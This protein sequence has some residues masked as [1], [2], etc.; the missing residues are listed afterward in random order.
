MGLAFR[1]L[2][3]VAA[4]VLCIGATS[5]DPAKAAQP[6]AQPSPWPEVMTLGEAASFLR[7]TPV[8]LGQ[9]ADWRQVPGRRIGDQWRFSRAALLEWLEGAWGPYIAPYEPVASAAGA[10]QTAAVPARQPYAAAATTQPLGAQALP[11]AAMA[12]VTA[13]GTTLAQSEAP[14]APAEPTAGVPEEPIGEAPEERTADEI[15]LRGQRVLLAPGDV[16]LDLA[17]F[18]SESDDRQLVP[19]GGGFSGLGTIE[20]ET[21]T[22]ALIGRYGL[23]EETELFSPAS[24]TET[25]IPGSSSATRRSATPRATSSATCASACAARCCTKARAGPTSSSPSTAAFRPATPPTRW[26]A[27][28]PWSRASTPPS[29]SPAPTTAIPS[30]GTSPT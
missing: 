15:F 18:Y 19:V 20:Q 5:A 14:P 23:F 21:F 30:A 8:E 24:P 13:A 22:T 1:R 28:S 27:G 17:L 25:K 9:L 26:A 4:L 6:A 16:V 11:P 2:R 29:C 7:M 3:W 10:Y 12:R